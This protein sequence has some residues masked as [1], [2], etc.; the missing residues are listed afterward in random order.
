MSNNSENVIATIGENVNLL[1]LDENDPLLSGIFD[2]ENI[3]GNHPSVSNKLSQE[4]WERFSKNELNIEKIPFVDAKI[5]KWIEQKKTYSL[6]KSFKLL[7]DE[8]KVIWNNQYYQKRS[9][10][11]NEATFTHDLLVPIL[12]FIAPSYFKRW[13]QAQC[14]SSKE[15]GVLKYVDIVGSVENNNRLFE[16]FFVEVSHGPFH[17]HP[18]DHI[19]EDDHK[20]SKLG[21]DALDR[22][23]G[24][25]SDDYVILFHLRSEYLYVYLMDRKFNPVIRKILIDKIHIPFYNNSPSEVLL[26][27]IKNL[28]K[29]RCILQSL[30]IKFNNV[31]NDRF[32]DN[33][34]SNFITYPTPKK[35]KIRK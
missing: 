17:P 16:L 29:F 8:I 25:V 11:I 2:V 33:E 24:Y 21:K 31:N 26:D 27:F 23:I 18:E 5:I 4:D 14:F 1:N 13:D 19:N 32:H 12:K 7:I 28:W 9:H 22:N 10:L 34:I 15:R 20:L 6:R 3:K 30:Y 35:L